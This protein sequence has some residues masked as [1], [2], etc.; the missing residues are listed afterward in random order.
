[1]VTQTTKMWSTAGLTVPLSGLTF[2]MGY[3]LSHGQ[4]L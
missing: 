4:F 2:L 1:M 3:E